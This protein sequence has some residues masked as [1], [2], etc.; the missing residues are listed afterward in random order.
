MNV[1]A[2][3]AIEIIGEKREAEKNKVISILGENGEYQVLNG[4]FG[5]YFS[6]EKNNYKIPKN[7]DPQTLTTEKCKE[8]V[9]KQG[10]A[11]PKKKGFGKK[12]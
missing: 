3:R 5:P 4:R 12:K 7:I 10:T 1:T 2:E 8:L 9:E 6:F 11:K